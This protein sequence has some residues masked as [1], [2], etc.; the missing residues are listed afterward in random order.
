MHTT[1]LPR[2]SQD[3]THLKTVPRGGASGAANQEAILASA[4]AAIAA[5]MLGDA[6]APAVAAAMAYQ[7][8]CG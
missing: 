1:M 7:A 2:L 3:E 8:L 6:I 5:V 4:T